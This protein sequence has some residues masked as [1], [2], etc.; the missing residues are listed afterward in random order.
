MDV[1]AR[2]DL[3]GDGQSTGTGRC[4]RWRL[5]RYWLNGMSSNKNSVTTPKFP[6]P[7]R[8]AQ[9]R[10]GCSVADAV[11]D[12]PSAVTTVASTHASMDS[13]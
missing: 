13:P 8:S 10:S 4:T 9:K 11:R 7:P 12:A 6:Q 3:D 2:R 1:A 5:G